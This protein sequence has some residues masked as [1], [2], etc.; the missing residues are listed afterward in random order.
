M[1]TTTRFVLPSL[2][3]AFALVAL[4]PSAFAV[5]SNIS[6]TLT[7]PEALP[8]KEGD[9]VT[10]TANL[11]NE[12]STSFSGYTY[13]W[14]GELLKTNDNSYLYWQPTSGC[15]LDGDYGIRCAVTNLPAGSSKY[16]SMTLKR[17]KLC[18]KNNYYVGSR[19]STETPSYYSTQSEQSTL[20]TGCPVAGTSAEL[21]GPKEYSPGDTITMK[22]RVKNAG[23]AATKGTTV[24][25]NVPIKSTWVKE[26]SS[27][28]AT[29]APEGDYSFSCTVPDM[30]KGGDKTYD[31][32]F[33]MAQRDIDDCRRTSSATASAYVQSKGSYDSAGTLSELRMYVVCPK[34]VKDSYKAPV[35]PAKTTKKAAPA[36]KITGSK[37]MKADTATKYTVTVTNVGAVELTA[38]DQM[39]VQTPMGYTVTAPKG[40]N[41]MQRRDFYCTIGKLAPKAKKTFSFTVT[42]PASACLGKA[43]ISANVLVGYWDDHFASI[44]VQCGKATKK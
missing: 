17:G 18:N 16:V 31:L 19:V 33:T 29:C 6:M 43:T 36:V 22:V 34:G 4:P 25:M 42:A 5:D 37:S 8:A 23:P 15:E 11:F 14:V 40:C 2:A 35:A 28:D 24:F 9:A 7:K 39:Q 26:S 27:A 41:E 30:A 3:L 32:T 1:H 12:G 38:K 44:D 21:T 20:E 10:W 13:F